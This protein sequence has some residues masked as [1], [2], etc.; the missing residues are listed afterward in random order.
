MRTEFIV[1]DCSVLGSWAVV[2]TYVDNVVLPRNV[3]ERNG[4]DVGVEE[5]RNVDHGEHVAHTLGTERIGQNFNGV[6]NKETRPRHVV[7]SVV[8][9]DHKDDGTSVGLDLGGFEALGENGPDD[10]GHAHSSGGD[11]EKRATSELVDEKAHGDGNETVPDVQNTVDLE[12]HVGVGDTDGVEH[13]GDIVRDETVARPLGEQTSR[14]Q[15]KKPVAIALGLEKL[16]PASLL[17]LLLNGDGLLD[18]LILE[19]D[20]F[21]FSVAFGVKLGKDGK[22]ALGLALGDVPTR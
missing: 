22:G 8:Q 3:V 2:A 21:V 9:E 15:D 19:H 14:E 5:E 4:V 20:E 11:E 17:S 7:E 12:L 6:T 18:L 13:T 1:S 16:E 10:K